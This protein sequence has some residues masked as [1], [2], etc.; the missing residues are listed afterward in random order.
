MQSEDDDFPPAGPATPAT[1]APPG[2]AFAN[3]GA[4]FT[5]FMPAP[6]RRYPLAACTL[7]FGPV[8]ALIG[9]G[10]GLTNLLARGIGIPDL[11]AA[12]LAVG[13]GLLLTG[14]LHEDGL[15]D[16]ADALGAA[17]R[18]QALAIMRDS[19]LGSFGCLALILSV[20]LRVAAIA[21]LPG[22]A[23]LAA[24][25]GAHAV[26]RAALAS[27]LERLTP[28]RRDGLG[29]DA[30]RPA[31]GQALAALG[32]A[33]AIA[34]L[35]ALVLA[36]IGSALFALVAGGV[37]GL[38]ALEVARRRFGGYTGDV[39]GGLQQ[40]MEVAMLLAFAAIL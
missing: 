16:S 9:L 2:A 20:G 38:A 37:G 33:A 23:A 3:A 22:W 39:L 27:V 24:L 7:G 5:R 11:A 26:S 14:A 6:E 15:A 40:C 36:D 28:L 12:L 4:F 21:A 1:P 13:C 18:R 17:D 8:G 30:G 19:R 34:V 25:I 35:A 10:V 31:E 29:A 32:I